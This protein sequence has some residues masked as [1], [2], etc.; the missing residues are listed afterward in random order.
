MKKLATLVPVAL[1][2]AL[3]GC[4]GSP[5]QAASENVGEADQA[6]T[7]AGSWTGLPASN[8]NWS[9]CVWSSSALQYS[10]QVKT[11]AVQPGS[12]DAYDVVVYIQDSNGNAVYSTTSQPDH[13]L[14]P[15]GTLNF[16]DSNGSSFQL[17]AGTDAHGHMTLAMQNAYFSYDGTTIACAP[18]VM[19]ATAFASSV[20]I[21]GAPW[22]GSTLTGNYTFSDNEGLAQSGSTFQWNRLSGG[23][24]TAISGATSTTYTP[25]SADLGYHLQFCVTPS[26]ANGAGVQVCSNPTPTTAAYSAVA[27]NVTVSG[28]PYM[29]S[30]L[31]GS[32]TFS[33]GAN[34][35]QTSVAYQWYTVS[36][37][38]ATAISGAT[39]S[40]YSPTTYDVNNPIELC[41]T[42]SDSFGPGAQAC[43]STVTVPGVVWF[44]AESWTGTATSEVS[45]NGTCVTVS[46]LALG[47]T[48]ASLILYS[49]DDQVASINMYDG[50]DCTGDVYNRYTG[51]GT[52][53][54]INLDTVGIGSNL[55]SYQITW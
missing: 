47:Y 45:A 38:T 52:E 55:V 35:P 11:D 16:S 17:I 50:A 37:G 12:V 49:V 40:T 33:D 31:T 26:D 39:S 20:G 5:V 15:G 14:T 1:L 22:I 32:F 44:S 10:M 24:A 43:S 28:N 2:A 51:N 34:K 21:G 23:T 42:P 48:P 7:Q 3:T 9:S 46:A 6:S 30:T 19:L 53:H 8:A 54:D 27:S 36:G 25:T 4:T 13:T 18:H 29:G 41:V